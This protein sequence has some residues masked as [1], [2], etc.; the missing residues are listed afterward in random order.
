MTSAEKRPT[1][2][3][4]QLLRSNSGRELRIKKTIAPRW[5]DFGAA[6]RFSGS[7][8]DIIEL[9]FQRDVVRCANNLFEQWMQ[10]ASDCTWRALIAA[11]KDA[12]FENLAQDVT[13]ALK[14]ID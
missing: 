11:L 9:T 1:L 2:K 6:L 3:Q 14:Y 7:D 13:E 4:F 8:L 10:K 12:E 5:R